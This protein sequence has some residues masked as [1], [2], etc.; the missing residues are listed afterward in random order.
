MFKKKKKNLCSFISL[1]NKHTMKYGILNIKWS[2]VHVFN[3]STLE[4]DLFELEASLVY[5]LNS[6]TVE[7]YIVKP[8]LKKVAGQWCTPLI[9]ALGRQRQADF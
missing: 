5:I 2:Q 7:N 8:Y 9:P 1:E 6:R 4:A 3:S